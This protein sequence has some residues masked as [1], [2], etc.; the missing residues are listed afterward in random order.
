[1]R[2]DAP[3]D[4]PAI[5]R[6]LH[7]RGVRVIVFG[8]QA[9]RALG[10]PVFT[11]DYDLWFESAAREAVLTYFEEELG[12][13]LSHSPGSRAPVISVLTGTDKIDAWFV[14]GMSNRE[15]ERI[16]YEG[17]WARSIELADPETGF[18]LRVPSLDDMIALKKVAPT[19]RDKDE[20]DIRYLLVRKQLIRDGRLPPTQ[21]E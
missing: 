21:G 12:Y 18:R 10:A 5:L 6:T 1:M 7:E 13:D 9:M 4:F 11:Q 14:R 20:E 15:R 17:V 3:F 2:A 8:R 16:D 19:P